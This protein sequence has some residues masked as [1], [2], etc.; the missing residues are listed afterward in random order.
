MATGKNAE[1]A[2]STGA[3]LEALDDI[4]PELRHLD[5]LV[6]AFRILGEADDAIEPV[7]VSALARCARETLEEIER[8]WRAAIYALRARSA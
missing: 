2:P 3:V 1:R 7:A 5:G 4:E 6:T 8:N